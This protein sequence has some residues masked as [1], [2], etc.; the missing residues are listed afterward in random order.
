MCGFSQEVKEL[1]F[2]FLANRRQKVKL[3]GVFPDFEILNHGV[4][5]GTVLGPLIFLLYV[6]DF[7]SNISTTE[8]VIQFAD[9][10]SIVCCGEKGSLHGKVTEILQKNRR[11]CRDEQT[12]FEYKQKRNN[13]FMRN[14]SDFGSTFYKNEVLTTQKIAVI[15]VFKLTRIF[16]SR[17]S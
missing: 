6:N 11:I 12:I 2:S 17:S 9:D 3:N 7:S 13:F 5:Q 15:L 1:L 16:V 4:P 8:N 10:T 14:N